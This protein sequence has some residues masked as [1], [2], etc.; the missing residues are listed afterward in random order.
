MRM[1]LHLFWVKVP[2]RAVSANAQAHRMFT[3]PIVNPEILL[4]LPCNPTLLDS[5]TLA[6]CQTAGPIATSLLKTLSGSQYPS[7]RRKPLL[8]VVANL[9]PEFGAHGAR[10]PI[11]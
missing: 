6:A 2:R 11:P 8:P 10:D 9:R 4:Q 1:L 5:Q 3:M 7:R